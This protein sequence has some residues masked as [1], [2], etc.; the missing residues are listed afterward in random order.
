M[1]I[2]ID[3][4]TYGQLTTTGLITIY[5][6]PDNM[7]AIVKS[8]RFVNTDSSPITLDAYF[9]RGGAAARI[10]PASLSLGAGQLLVDDS[11]ITL[12][13]GDQIQAQASEANKIDYVLSG[14]VRD[15]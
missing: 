15:A 8:M 7:A 4:L 9:K 1:A 3:N 2:T 14:I 10:L 5:T 12:K 13:Q 11:E 6:V